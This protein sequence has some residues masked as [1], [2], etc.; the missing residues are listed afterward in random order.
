MAGA[1]EADWADDRA[2]H[3]PD[4]DLRRELAR[5]LRINR[6]VIDR[7]VNP[8]LLVVEPPSSRSVADA[9]THF[10]VWP[11]NN[12]W[13]FVGFMAGLLVGLAV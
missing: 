8:P 5:Q 11:A 4:Q 9:A 3:V 7:Q 10:T 1:E 6:R 12:W 2:R 13:A